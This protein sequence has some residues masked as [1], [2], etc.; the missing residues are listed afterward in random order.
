M[1]GDRRAVN[2]T[3]EM[4]D[5]TLVAAF[6]KRRDERAFR[7]LYSRQT[8]ALYAL[9][10]R[11][12]GGHE[13]NAQ[14]VVQEAWVRAGRALPEFRWAS[15]LRTWLCGFV[16][17][18]VREV[19]RDRAAER[20]AATRHDANVTPAMVEERLDLEGAIARL[21]VGY[22]QVL[23]LR[24]VEGYTHQEIGALLDIDAGTSRSQWLRARNAVGELLAGGKSR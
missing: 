5:R 15:S 18:V 12:L 21:P 13:A 17:N 11:L 14:D 23:I 4:T 3:D 20:D 7:E 24:A 2:P 22:R 16:V 8:P 9:A 10:L 6:L 1:Y 19:S